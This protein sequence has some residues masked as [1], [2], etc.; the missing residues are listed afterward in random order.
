MSAARVAWVGRFQG[1]LHRI[2]ISP[3]PKSF[4][5]DER[6]IFASL[7]VQLPA[8]TIVEAQCTDAMGED[9]WSLILD[10]RVRALVLSACIIDRMP[11][12]PASIHIAP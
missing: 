4:T 6:A 8:E 9:Y 11:I 5:K 12:Q 2:V 3:D 1:Q 10:E 7:D